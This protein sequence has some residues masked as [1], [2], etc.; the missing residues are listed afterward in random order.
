MTVSFNNEALRQFRKDIGMSLHNARIAKH[1]TLEKLS[2]LTGFSPDLLDR[3]EMG[4]NCIT[5]DMMFIIAESLDVDP[6][7]IIGRMEKAP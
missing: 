1:Y 5:F 6:R 2:Q 3:M 4:R 7:Q